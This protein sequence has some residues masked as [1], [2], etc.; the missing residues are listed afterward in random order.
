M[1]IFEQALMIA[2]KKIVRACE[3]YIDDELRGH[4]AQWFSNVLVLLPAV[5][6]DHFC[7]NPI[8]L[9]LCEMR[10]KG[11]IGMFLCQK[12]I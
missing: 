6:M 9:Q 2:G 3:K 11:S 8:T 4:V 5:V 7:A 10:G 12:I 1:D